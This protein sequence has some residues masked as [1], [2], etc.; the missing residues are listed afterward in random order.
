MTAETDS[1]SPKRV[2]IVD[3]HEL[4]RMAV[5]QLIGQ[6]PDLVT[7]GEAEDV[8]GALKAIAELNPD[9]AVVD[10]S[11]KQSHGIELIK[12]IKIRWPHL[13]VLVLSM[14]DESFYAERVLRSGARG[15]VTKAEVSSK[16]IEGLRKVLDGEVYVSDALASKMLSKLIGGK[17]DTTSF[18]VDT[19]SDREFEV[20]ELI[21]QGIQSRD[22]AQALKVSIKTVDA[23]REHLKKKLGVE[24]RT[25]L[26]MYAMQ[27]VQFD[28]DG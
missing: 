3:D 22:I 8:S 13:P 15:Y 27:W 18:P 2:L 19:L 23:H 12:D 28:R 7:C 11:L 24:T 25:D 9:V 20:F 14:H 16:V 4:V 10:I 26:L 17:P 1:S 6:E 5:A 21:G